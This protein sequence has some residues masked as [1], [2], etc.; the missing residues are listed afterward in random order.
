MKEVISFFLH[1]LH[2]CFLVGRS[3]LGRG[4][5][6]VGNAVP[7]L[8]RAAGIAFAHLVC[9][10]YVRLLRSVVLVCL[11]QF[12]YEKGTKKNPSRVVIR[13]SLDHLTTLVMTSWEM[14]TLLHKRSEMFCLA[15][16]M[17][18]L[19]SLKMKKNPQ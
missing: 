19:G 10:L 17:A 7:Q 5:D 14:S 8:W 3:A 6:D 9:Q 2:L 11:G 16:S 15:Y 18:P 4:H 13:L 12:L 1:W